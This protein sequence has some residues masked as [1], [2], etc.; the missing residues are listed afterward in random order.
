MARIRAHSEANDAADVERGE[1]RQYDGD[2]HHDD[3]SY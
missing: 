3:D 2:D 1:E